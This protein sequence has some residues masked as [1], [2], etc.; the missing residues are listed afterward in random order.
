MLGHEVRVPV[1]LL[2]DMTYSQHSLKEVCSCLEDQSRGIQHLCLSLLPGTPVP[3]DPVPS[4]GT[5]AWNTS[6]EGSNTSAWPPRHQ[7]YVHIHSHK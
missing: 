4:P 2:E 3:R 1:A 6:P 7:T 5:I